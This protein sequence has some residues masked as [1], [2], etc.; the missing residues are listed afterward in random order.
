[1]DTNR[2]FQFQKRSQLFV[3][4]HNEVLTVSAMGG[5]NPFQLEGLTVSLRLVTKLPS[6]KP[7]AS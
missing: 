6:I 4:A 2:P 3:G 1:V 5:N 7:G